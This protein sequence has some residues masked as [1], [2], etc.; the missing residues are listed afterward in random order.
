MGQFTTVA[1]PP[2]YREPT[3]KSTPS[4]ETARI[5]S[6]SFSGGCDRS[7]SI[8]HMRWYGRSSAHLNPSR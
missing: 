2:T 1:F 8:S 5:S 4:S 7:A 6:G 3:T